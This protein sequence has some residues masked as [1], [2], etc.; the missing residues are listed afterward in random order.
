MKKLLE[1]VVITFFIMGIIC[2]VFYTI[3]WLKNWIEIFTMFF[4][5]IFVILLDMIKTVV[6]DKFHDK[7]S[8]DTKE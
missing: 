2:A 1:D 5:T 7:K 8:T 6:S 3:V 4:I